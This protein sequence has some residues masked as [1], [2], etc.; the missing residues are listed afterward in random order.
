MNTTATATATATARNF[1]D[2]DA[3]NEEKARSFLRFLNGGAEPDLSWQEVE[4][5]LGDFLYRFGGTERAEREV[6]EVQYLD[7]NSKQSRRAVDVIAQ[8]FVGYR[9]YPVPFF[10]AA[11]FFE[12]VL[13]GCDVSVRNDE[14]WHKVD[15]FEAATFERDLA[16]ART[17]EVVAELERVA[18][19][20]DSWECRD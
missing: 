20:Q 8:V 10:V 15:Y 17:P 9:D 2:K 12:M 16:A 19:Y 6:I 18:Q 7:A 5:F 3:T 1:M 13:D 11:N 4:G 14:D